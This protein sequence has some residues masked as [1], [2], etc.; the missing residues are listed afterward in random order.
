MSEKNWEQIFCNQ[1]CSLDELNKIYLD[2]PKQ[3]FLNRSDAVQ[4][5]QQAQ[6]DVLKLVIQKIKGKIPESCAIELSQ[7]LSEYLKKDISALGMIH[8]VT[9]EQITY[10]ETKKPDMQIKLDLLP[11]SNMPNFLTIK[12]A[13]GAKQDGLQEGFKIPVTDLNKEQAEQYG[14]MMKQEFIKHWE[15]KTILKKADEQR[16]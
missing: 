7:M 3:L 5:C 10:N 9:K 15:K 8:P 14:E 6:I 1:L 4:I 11:P 12:R 2:E 13:D 16:A